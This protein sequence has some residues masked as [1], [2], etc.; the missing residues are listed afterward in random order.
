[1]RAP[2]DESGGARSQS[3]SATSTRR[4]WNMALIVPQLFSSTGFGVYG[5]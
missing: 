1:M 5:P 2:P 4:Y 3:L